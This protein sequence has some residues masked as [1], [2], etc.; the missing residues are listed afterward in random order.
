MSRALLL[1]ERGRGRTSPN[2]MVGAVVVSA[3]G[4]VVGS[5]YHEVAGGPH[6]EVF[7][8]RR[9]G[10]RARGATLYC[11]LE[12]CC[13]VGRT[14]P[15]TERIL[16]AGIARVVA[17]VADPNPRV[18]GGGFAQLREH[19][20]AVDEGLLADE[21]AALN[22]AFFTWVSTGRPFVIAKAALSMNATVASASG[23][24][25]QLTSAASNRAVH[26]DRAAVDAIAVG[27]ET[28]LSDDPRL[29]ARGAWRARPL[30]RVIFDRRL[31]TPPS[32]RVFSTPDAGPVIIMST[33][34]HISAHP[35]RVR[36]LEKAG[37]EVE[38]LPDDSLADA[39]Q[40]LGTRGITSLLLEGGPRL[41][42]AAWAAGVID[43]LQLYITPKS[44]AD[45]VRWL[46]A[47][48][49]PLWDVRSC[50]K[51]YGPDVSIEVYVHRTH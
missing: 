13:H 20:V 40:R 44:L 50:V 42:R 14:G 2:P 6:A 28:I 27:S 32:A 48:E 9:A 26:L 17:A 33:A 41:H 4:V 11:T 36:A 18:G 38:G 8:L 45:G 3:E 37:A 51:A 15:C 19:G 7:A 1:A 43:L 31:R 47:E 34:A 10:E 30:P 24:P 23:S 5:G 25:A 39:L 16:D 12:P 49:L 35:D 29:T 46:S 21:A 22:A